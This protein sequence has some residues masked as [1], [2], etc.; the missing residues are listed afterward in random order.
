MTAP[1]AALPK[2]AELTPA[3]LLSKHGCVACHGVTNKIIGPALRD[4]AVKY[5]GKDGLEDYLAGKIRK[6]GAGLWGAIPMPAQT[7]LQDSDVKA[8]AAW[9]ANGAR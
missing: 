6:G 9:L 5:K 2:V 1:V 7:Q 4:V 3:Q 8:I